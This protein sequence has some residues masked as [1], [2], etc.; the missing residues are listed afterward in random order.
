MDNGRL[1]DEILKL[2]MSLDEKISGSLTA[3]MPTSIWEENLG[4][5]LF[6]NEARRTNTRLF[7]HNFDEPGRRVCHVEKSSWGKGFGNSKIECA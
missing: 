4:P 5:E 7:F 3:A 1:R 2:R 6:Q